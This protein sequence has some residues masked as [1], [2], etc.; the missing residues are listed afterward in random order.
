M[1][2]GTEI[3]SV[4]QECPVRVGY[5]LSEYVLDGWGHV[6]LFHVLLGFHS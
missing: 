6:E 2:S 3:S 5:T 4:E 1:W